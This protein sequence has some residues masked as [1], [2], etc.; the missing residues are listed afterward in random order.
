MVPFGLAAPFINI[1]CYGLIW[2]IAGW[3]Y[4][5]IIFG[6]YIL[7]CILQVWTNRAQKRIKKTENVKNVQRMQ[8][9]SDMITGIRT[10]KS[11][12]GEKNYGQKIRQQREI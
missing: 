6:L 2:Y 10:I 3:P 12:A 5:V 11:Y 7:T 8:L 9:I 4:A 1:A